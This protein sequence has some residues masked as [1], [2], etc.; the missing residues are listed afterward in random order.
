MNGNYNLAKWLLEIK[1]DI[2]ISADDYYAF[3]NAFKNE[4]YST[5][6]WLLNIDPLIDIT[7]DDDYA[8]KCA[9]KNLH[10]EISK[11]LASIRPDRYK[12][13]KITS[14]T[15][16]YKITNFIEFQKTEIVEELE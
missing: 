4:H 14:N 9:C 3:R 16:D 6:L 12:I 7:V 13:I 15:I 5:T 8:F 2:N 10:H 11:L 1:P